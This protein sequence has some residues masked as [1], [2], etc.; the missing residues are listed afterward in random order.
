MA[1]Q[2]HRAFWASWVEM[3]FVTDALGENAKSAQ[4]IQAATR[5]PR[6]QIY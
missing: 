6:F 5:L 4:L 2:R 3:L 1:M